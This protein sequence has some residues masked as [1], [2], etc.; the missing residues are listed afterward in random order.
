VEVKGKTYV[1][2]GRTFNAKLAANV[3]DVIRIEVTEILYD[4]SGQ[5][6]K[7]RGFTPTV[8]DKVS[9]GPSS[10]K[11]I[12]SSLE[13]GETKKSA[14]EV[15][16][17]VAKRVGL[18]D[19]GF[20]AKQQKED[21]RYVL[22]VVLVPNEYDSQGDIYDEDTV[23]KAS[24]Y[25]ME[26][27]KTLGLMHEKALSENKVRILENYIAPCDMEIEGQKVKKG[28]WLL[29]ARILD[30]ELWRAVKNGTL[31]GWSIEGSALAQY[32]H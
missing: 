9:E 16:E 21:E 13:E 15:Q 28:T 24:E 3:G 30:D 6:K 5:K 29:A 18:G 11:E 4:T 20:V 12:L 32:V 14:E 22:G 31:T 8:I 27:A 26:H 25:F 23:R 2:A 1:K 19:W 17:S 7:I 10:I